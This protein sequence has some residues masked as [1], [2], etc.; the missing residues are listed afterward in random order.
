MIKKIKSIENLAVYQNFDWDSAVREKNGTVSEFKKLN[1]IYGRNYSGKTTLSRIFR[2][3]ETGFLSSNYINPVFAIEVSDGSSITQNQLSNHQQIIRVFNEDFIKENLQF[4]ISDNENVKPFAILGDENNRIENEIKENEIIL[5][6]EQHRTGLSGE[7]IEKS[8]HYNVALQA[9]QN[10][11]LMLDQKLSNKAINRDVGIKYNTMYEEP[12][13][14]ITK[15]KT[16]IATVQSPSYK[17]ISDEESEKQKQLLRE[18]SKPILPESQKLNLHYKSLVSSTK[19]LLEK[20]ITVS[21]PILELLEDA[22]LQNWV[23]SGKFLHEETRNTCGFCNQILPKNLLKKLDNHFNKDSEELYAS[24]ES[25]IKKIEQEITL[26]NSLKI[27]D[28][29]EFYSSI[30]IQVN[31]LNIEFHENIKKYVTCLSFLISK[32][33]DRL[34]NIF[35]PINALELQ[36]SEDLS[37]QL[38]SIRN[39]YEAFRIMSNELTTNL[40]KQ[41]QNAR[42]VLRLNEI[43]QFINSINYSVEMTAIKALNTTVNIAEREKIDTNR[44]VNEVKNTI[45]ILKTQIK[46]ESKGAERVNYYLKHFFGHESLSLTAVQEEAQSGYRFE[47]L[48]NGIKAHH[49]S[50][51]ECSLVAFCY[52][53]AKLEDVET[54]GNMPIIWIDDPIS[55]LDENHIFYVYSL[56]NT[57]LIQTGLFKQLFIST[58][59]LNFLKYLKRLFPKDLQ[60]NKIDRRYF[61]V[62][63][64]NAGSRLNIMP[65]Y[66]ESNMTE[67]N[68]LFQQI[69]ICSVIEDDQSDQSVSLFYNYGNNARKFLEMYLYYKYPNEGEKFDS[70]LLRFFGND[71]L[72]S[73]LADR[74]HNEYSHLSGVF[75]RSMRPIEIPELKKTAQLIINQIKMHD[76][77]QYQAL[78]ASIGINEL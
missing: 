51:G 28:A 74:I 29:H 11:Q 45:A 36:E 9:E 73:V 40:H 4:I 6:S 16:D 54:K 75:E 34:N 78:L 21:E 14:N 55:S 50:E 66:L 69:Y 76:S 58:H 2:S 68:Y 43:Y 33:Q 39:R 25:L 47:I 72:S 52:F 57:Q 37:L 5:G 44:K 42:K 63:K 48:R 24:I 56:I 23:R 64:T 41:Q 70:K 13:Y 8:N 31:E 71:P 15:L 60:G 32:L 46:D 26:I 1:I 27:F 10:Q 3:L 20:K 12:N 22:V 67:F 7:L 65:S 49:M 17:N 59:N 62:E 35:A 19:E 53:I 77:D 61:I 18:N 30:A 38:E